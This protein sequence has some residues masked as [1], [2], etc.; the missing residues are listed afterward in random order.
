M[1]TAGLAGAGGGGGGGGACTLLRFAGGARTAAV[2]VVATGF[3]AAA[4]V[5]RIT[6]VGATEVVVF[7]GRGRAAGLGLEAGLGF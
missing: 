1:G 5:A 2:E 4:G 6:G 7:P 3:G